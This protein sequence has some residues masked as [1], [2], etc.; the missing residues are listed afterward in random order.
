MRSGALNQCLRANENGRPKPPANRIAVEDPIG[1]PI[2][3]DY[4]G[5]STLSITWITPLL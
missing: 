4:F 1:Y 3:S 5:S 2:V